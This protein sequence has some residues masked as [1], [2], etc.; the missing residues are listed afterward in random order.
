[1]QLIPDELRRVMAERL[2]L[3]DQ[4]K[5]VCRIEV[6]RMAFVPGRVQSLEF[7]A[8]EGDLPVTYEY[9]WINESA[10]GETVAN[11]KPFTYPVKGKAYKDVTVT[12]K[13]G[14]RNGKLHKGID[15]G[16]ALGTELV[17]ALDGTVKKVSMRDKNISYGYYVEIQHADGV[18]SRYAHLSEI[19][20]T[21]GMRVAAGDVIAKSGNTGDSTG[22]HLHF[23]IWFNNKPVDPEQFMTGEKQLYSTS[24]TLGGVSDGQVAGTISEQI[25]LQPFSS[26]DWV[27]DAGITGTDG[28]FSDHA[29]VE[30]L[31][32]TSALKV[33]FGLEARTTGFNARI[34]MKKPGLV[35]ARIAADVVDSGDF[36]L[37]IGGKLQMK[38]VKF[39]GAK[40]FEDFSQAFPPGDYDVRVE[41][42]GYGNAPATF[43]LDTLQ[44]HALD[45]RPDLTGNIK[46]IDPTKGK[47]YYQEMEITNLLTGGSAKMENLQVGEFV[48]MDTLVLDNL[49]TVEIDDQY[50]M[51]SR[52]AR[53]TISNPGGYYSPDFNPYY[54]PEAYQDSPWSY[55]INGFHYGVLSENTPIRIF[56][57]YGQ[58][59][60][61]V[62]TGLIDKVDLDS[63]NAQISISARD[64]Y[65]KVLNKVITEDK[66]YPREGA[67]T[68]AIAVT[69]VAHDLTR[70]QEIIAKAKYY[71][72]KFPATLDYRFLLAICM[73]ETTFG[74]LGKWN[75][76]P[77]DAIL[78]YDCPGDRDPRP[79]YRGI[80][81]QLYYGAR[82]MF[83]AL[84][85]RN[86]TISSLADVQYFWEGGDKGAYQWAGDTN[87]PNGVWTIYQQYQSSPPADFE[88]TPAWTENGPAVTGTAPGEEQPHDTGKEA[89]WLKSSIITDL[90]MHAGLTSWRRSAIDIPY[91]DYIIEET[92]LIELN[93]KSGKVVKAVPGKEGEF[94]EED[95]NSILTP[96]GWL[97]PFVDLQRDWK[98]FQAKVSDCISDVINDT[99]FRSYCDRN[100]T[101]RLEQLNFNKP[102][103]ALFTEYDNLVSLHKT[104]DYTRA[105]SHIIIGDDKGNY[106]HFVD[107]ELLMELKGELRTTFLTVPYARTDEAKRQVAARFFWDLKRL[108]RTL[109]VTIPGNPALDVLDQVYI[110]DKTTTTRATYTIKG[111]RSS[112]S[113][114]DGYMQFVDLMWSGEGALL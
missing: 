76:P 36:K 11:A 3:G 18:W 62:F 27:N 102:V 34:S 57:G 101:Y 55:F 17:A 35:M 97:N 31:E 37:Y 93:Q 66:K 60:V 9:T 61:R 103:V 44:V 40:V 26:K 63:E 67:Y 14:Q 77:F 42:T 38:I 24:T 51:D 8:N 19:L 54:F 87:W 94:I 41:F 4:A 81:A 52:E 25:L 2:K 98:A 16:V 50:E 47:G 113:V 80:G 72:T 43:L 15:L 21:T 85:S 45:G 12:S 7:I 1:M 84:K 111:I 114:S 99:N 53:I 29:S 32:N 106:K 30:W 83:E 70:R 74:T 71:C 96:A 69:K 13:Y 68:T 78:S 64:M 100:G 59:M 75:Q 28:N 92:Y 10:G 20:V 112:F 89:A 65:K 58:N 88:S 23:E 104:V 22:P 79:E 86:W 105:R 90:I 107:T 91:P 48:Y 46:D 82:R 108:C 33:S 73:Q 56:M 110:S 95:A 6:D 109:Q 39:K 49:I 5:P